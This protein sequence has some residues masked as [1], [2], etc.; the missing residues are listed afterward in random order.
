ME[1]EA[2]LFE[3]VLSERD[4]PRG[5][6]KPWDPWHVVM[7]TFF[8]GLLGG[9][10]LV[11][12]NLVKLGDKNR[13]IAFGILAGS[14]AV[15]L[16]ALGYWAMETDPWDLGEEARSYTFY[17]RKAVALLAAIASIPLQRHRFHV[18]THAGGIRGRILG[19]AV[20]SL[21]VAYGIEK[22]IEANMG[23]AGWVPR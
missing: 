22:V 11:T 14:A 10:A 21:L 8:I 2:D 17:G 13:A 20:I 7:A 18:Y 1:R 15:S 19:P 6:D 23:V 4:D 9:T 5:F 3:P 16:Y 12:W